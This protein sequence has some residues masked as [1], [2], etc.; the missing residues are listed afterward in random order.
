[1]ADTLVIEVIEEIPTLE[2]VIPCVKVT[3]SPTAPTGPT[4]GDLWVDTT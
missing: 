1:M 2:V 4:K 3:V